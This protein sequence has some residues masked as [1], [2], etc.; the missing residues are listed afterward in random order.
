MTSRL[1]FGWYLGIMA[2]SSWHKELTITGS[3]DSSGWS[4]PAR[5]A[6]MCPVSIARLVC[7]GPA[8]EDSWGTCWAI[9]L[10][11]KEVVCSSSTTEHN[12][13]GAKESTRM[14]PFHL[15]RSSSPWLLVHVRRMWGY[16]SSTIIMAQSTVLVWA[17]YMQCSW[18]FNQVGESLCFKEFRF[19]WHVSR[20]WL[21]PGVNL[22]IPREQASPCL[23]H[24]SWA[25]Q[26]CS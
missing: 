6:Q 15:L 13:P 2:L 22:L 3:Q 26:S 5:E 11:T 19:W 8:W 21:L 9:L 25:G 24:R 20:S 16:S 12:F 4:S 23:A 1:V 10:A 7:L 18:Y 14:V 17:S